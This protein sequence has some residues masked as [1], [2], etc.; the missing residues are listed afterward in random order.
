[1]ETFIKSSNTATIAFSEDLQESLQS[2]GMSSLSGSLMSGTISAVGSIRSGYY[3]IGEMITSNPPITVINLVTSLQDGKHDFLR[4]ENIEFYENNLVEIFDRQG[5]K[6]FEMN[7][8]DNQ[9]RVFKGNANVGSRGIL[10]TGS[11][12]YAIR[13]SGNNRKTGFVY[14]KN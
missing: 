2:I 11:Y 9:D 5:V 13:L 12:Y 10:E 6:V 3:V 4:I 7:G 8:Y 1:E 14:V